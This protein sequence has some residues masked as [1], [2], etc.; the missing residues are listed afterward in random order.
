MPLNLDDPK[1]F[2]AALSRESA[3]GAVAEY[4]GKTVVHVELD[5]PGFPVCAHEGPVA[6][7]PV[8]EEN[9]VIPVAG[10]V[11]ERLSV[12]KPWQSLETDMG[13]WIEDLEF[14][15]NDTPD[16][17]FYGYFLLALRAEDGDIAQLRRLE[18]K[19]DVLLTGMRVRN[20]WR[21]RR[22]IDRAGKQGAVKPP[23]VQH[24]TH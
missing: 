23:P 11:G 19:A 8:L 16:S 3:H 21:A 5:W 4:F 17:A 10:L 15:P 2:R 20:R 1:K 14:D 24:K 9:L 6:G 13:S 12:D 22:T 7:Q 18:A